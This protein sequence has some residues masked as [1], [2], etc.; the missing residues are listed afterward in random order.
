MAIRLFA[1][2]LSSGLCLTA[3]PQAEAALVSHW[4]ADGRVQDSSTSKIHFSVPTVQSGAQSR[5]D[6]PMQL[7]T[8][9]ESPSYRIAIFPAHGSAGFSPDDSVVGH[10]RSELTLVNALASYVRANQALS[11]TYSPYTDLRIPV[12]REEVWQD[13][14]PNI[15]VVISFASEFDVHGVVMGWLG[16]F[17]GQQGAGANTLQLYV[18]DVGQREV[19]YVKGHPDRA[20]SMAKTALAAFL[21]GLRTKGS[22]LISSAGL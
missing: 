6:D 15:D 19:H 3:L 4:K 16:D 11:L 17:I 13:R 8:A 5:S 14:G 1:I 20:G 9:V 7:L 22:E 18:I 12:R 10:A 2:A 21:D